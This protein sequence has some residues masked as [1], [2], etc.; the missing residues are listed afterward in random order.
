MRTRKYIR[1]DDFIWLYN[2]KRK[3]LLIA[4]ILLG[5][6][7]LAFAAIGVGSIFRTSCLP[8]DAK[9]DPRMNI[10]FYLTD[11][12]WHGPVEIAQQF[13]KGTGNPRYDPGKIDD[14]PGPKF[15]K[16]YNN[17]KYDLYNREICLK[18]G[19]GK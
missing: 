18:M 13:L 1:H 5:I 4:L 11:D 2:L 15:R 19:D 6:A 12:G 3:A 7:V 10:G 9:I 17:Y 8:P 14:D 16:A